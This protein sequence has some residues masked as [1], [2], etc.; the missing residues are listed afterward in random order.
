MNISM[1][2]CELTQA[3]V[4]LSNFQR[5]MMTDLHNGRTRMDHDVYLA[6]NDRRT[7]TLG[8]AMRVVGRRLPGIALVSV[9]ALLP[10]V[11]SICAS[12]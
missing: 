11:G 10:W 4:S 1:W 8:I 12:L 2:D 3:G 9:L 5:Q 6:A 7:R